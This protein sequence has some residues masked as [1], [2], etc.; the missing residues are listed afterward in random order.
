MTKSSYIGLYSV[1]KRGDKHLK[2]VIYLD[3]A[4]T[5]HL[6]EEVLNEMMPYLKEQY[7]NPSSLYDLGAENKSALLIARKKIADTLSCEPQSIYFTSGGTESDNWALIGVAEQYKQY[8]RHIITTKIEH[9]A[10]LNSCHYLEKRGFDVTYLDVD[11]QGYVSPKKI[12]QAL[13]TDTILVSIMLANNEI[14]TIQP[15]AEIGSLLADHKALF[16]TDAV[17]AYGH[18][19][20]PVKEW[21]IDLLSASAHKFHGPKGTGFLYVREGIRLPSFMHGGQQ[22]R[23]KRAGTENVPGI[24]GMGKAAELAYHNLTE[25]QS[26]IA[27]LRDYM[28]HRIETEISYCHRNGPR[29]NR[30]ANNVN[31]SF[32]FVDGEALVILLDMEGICASAGSACNAGQAVASHVIQALHLP[33]DLARGTVRFTLGNETTKEDIDQTVDVLKRVLDKNRSLNSQYQAVIR[34]IP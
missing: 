27:Q 15:I 2:H 25:T 7:G 1:N 31:F 10:V 14:G 21:H 3:N 32:Q 22:E 20:I 11:E 9:H 23:G 29:I 16:H 33:D 12:R 26:R 17:Q 34:L 30:L 28:I 8:G 13:R 4:A 6:S 24:V 19:R 5:T 18:M